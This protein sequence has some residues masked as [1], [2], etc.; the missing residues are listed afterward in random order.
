MKTGIIRRLIL[1]IVIV[2]VASILLTY[3]LTY[4]VYQ[5]LYVDR[6]KEFLITHGEATVLH[7][8][9]DIH[10][11]QFNNWVRYNQESMG[12]KVK[13]IEGEYILGACLPPNSNAEPFISVTEYNR[14]V[15][16]EIISK[17]GKYPECEEKIMGVLVPLI[18]NNKFYGVLFLY[19]PLISIIDTFAEFKYFWYGYIL[20]FLF[21]GLLSWYSVSHSIIKPLKKMAVIAKRMTEGDFKEKINVIGKDEVG[22]LGSA[23][24]NLS[25]SLS[26]YITMLSKEKEQLSQVIQGVS[27]GLLIYHT[28]TGQ[29]IINPAGEKLLQ[30]IKCDK[31][32]FFHS[33]VLHFCVNQPDKSRTVKTLE[34]EMANKYLRLYIAPLVESENCTESWGYVTVFHDITEDYLREKQQRE[35]LAN[36][37]H[38][39]RTPLSYVQGYAEAIL[40]NVADTEEKKKRYLET[41]YNETRRMQR[42]VHDLL[43]LAQLE[44]NSYPMKKEN[45]LLND[46][47][48]QIKDQFSLPFEQQNVNLLIESEDNLVI[49]ADEDRITQVLTNIV[50]NALRHTPE[51]GTIKIEA[52]NIADRV[53]IKISDTG[54]GIPEEALKRIGERFFRVDK[55]RSRKRGGTGLGM[56]IVKQIIEKHHGEIKIESVVGEGTT[57]TIVLPKFHLA[58]D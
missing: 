3:V 4:F 47:L 33:K 49:Y 43:D 35:F 2:A 44:R 28:K 31:E 42:L 21:V 50:D 55:A 9:G 56:A 24:N 34:L 53:E 22:V 30:E 5:K 38:E 23:L 46:I 48:S 25:D 41:I 52:R 12:S 51:N 18:Y 45:L 57:V 58:I 7:F 11:E 20:I 10:S 27:D 17:I 15:K 14:L 29:I 19:M 13:L 6:V 16:G 36:V 8:N 39:L 40:D 54:E 37:S 32:K 26:N 1:S